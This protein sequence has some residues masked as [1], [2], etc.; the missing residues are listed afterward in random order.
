MLR[1]RAT[2]L[3][4]IVRTV[5]QLG[6]V[7]LM[8]WLGL[9][10]QFPGTGAGGAPIDSFCPFGAVESL[11]SLMDGFGFI[12]KTGTSNLV[13]LAA[14]GAVTVGL[15]GAFCGWLCPFGG[16][17]DWLSAIGRRVFGMQLRVPERVHAYLRHARWVVLGVIVLMSWRVLGLWF[18]DYD[19]FRALFHFKFESTLAYGLV[20]GTVLVGLAVERA[21]CLY[22]CPLGALV[23]LLGKFGLVKVR[24]AE[25]ACTDCG[26]CTS[27]CPMRIP[28]ERLDV[29]SDQHCTMCTDCVDACPKP[30]ALVLSTGVKGESLR[31]LAVG[32]AAVLLFFAIIGTGWTLG[33]W[34]TGRGCAGCSL[35]SPTAVVVSPQTT[36]AGAVVARLE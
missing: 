31:P 4:K 24:R 8:A 21:W 6:F 2:S 34:Q 30:G 7:G 16:L 12:R 29:V 27:R 25:D 18:A 33:F 36:R 32:I 22:L 9:R 14:L 1:S 11:P 5:V 28:V 15:S 26:A 17:Q 19:P 20:I 10:H 35:E 3:P 13:V 23:G